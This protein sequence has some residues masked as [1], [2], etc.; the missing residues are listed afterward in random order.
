MKNTVNNRYFLLPYVSIPGL[1]VNDGFKGNV[2]SIDLILPV[3]WL[4]VR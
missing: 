2:A 4:S 1:V 3:C